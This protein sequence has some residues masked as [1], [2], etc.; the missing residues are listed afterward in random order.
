MIFEFSEVVLASH[1]DR[2]SEVLSEGPA[3]CVGHLV[4]PDTGVGKLSCH[5]EPPPAQTGLGTVHHHP[6]MKAGLAWPQTGLNNLIFELIRNDH[7]LVLVKLISL[8]SRLNMIK[9]SLAM[10]ATEELHG[11]V[12]L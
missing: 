4:H 10:R 12:T 7:V 9:I 6:V 5:A 11:A 2:F 3:L 8:L 1:E